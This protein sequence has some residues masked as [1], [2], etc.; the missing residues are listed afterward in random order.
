MEITPAS[1]GATKAGLNH[2]TVTLARELGPDGVRVVGVA[3]GP[4]W[5][6]SWERDLE[7]SA[8]QEGAD[9][10]D[11]RGQVAE[12]SGGDTHLGRPGQPDEV[13]KTILW[14]ASPAASFITGTTLSVDGGYVKGV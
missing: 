3:P 6:E 11:L 1:Y 12:E 10:E 8:A 14:L 7:R 4:V 2:L 13:A 5:T 9:K